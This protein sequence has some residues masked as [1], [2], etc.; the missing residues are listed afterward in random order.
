MRR[1]LVTVATLVALAAPTDA[2]AG[3]LFLFD[4]TSAV[5]D[6]RVTIRT[7]SAQGSAVRLYLVRA[8]E[9]SSVGSKRDSRLAFVGPSLPAGS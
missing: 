8:D 4:R 7:S 9:A 6:E 5:P 3:Q 2:F 1:T